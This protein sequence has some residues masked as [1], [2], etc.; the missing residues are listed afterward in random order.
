ML[1]S[2]LVILTPPPNS[3]PYLTRTWSVP[4]PDSTQLTHDIGG[5]KIIIVGRDSHILQEILVELSKLLVESN[6]VTKFGPGE[7]FGR[8]CTSV[9]AAIDSEG[10]WVLGFEG[11]EDVVKLKNF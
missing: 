2:S 5:W 4:T 7:Q 8:F 10:E 9:D 3:K 11:I 1:V 6:K